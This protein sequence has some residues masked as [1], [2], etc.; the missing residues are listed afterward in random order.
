MNKHKKTSLLPKLFITFILIVAALFLMSG[1]AFSQQA[2]EKIKPETEKE[3]VYL[4]D[5]SASMVMDN[6]I[7][8]YR[9]IFPEVKA[10]ILG[11]IEGM[12]LDVR[13]KVII[14]T[15]DKDV[16][17][18]FEKEIRSDKD[19][20]EI[21]NK[22][23]SLEA[24]GKY[25][26]TTKAVME[27]LKVLGNE[28]GKKDGIERKVVIYLLTDGKLEPPC[29]PYI[30]WNEV[31][32]RYKDLKKVES[33]NFV[34]VLVPLGP[35]VTSPTG[36]EDEIP[37]K[38]TIRVTP[39]FIDFGELTTKG[40]VAKIELEPLSPTMKI[41]NA[42]INVTSQFKIPSGTL[43]INP[44]KFSVPNEK[45]E[46]DL[47][48]TLAG[49]TDISP[50][51]YE[52]KIDLD[53]TEEGLIL[54]PPSIKAKFSIVSFLVNPKTADFGR[55]KKG[56]ARCV[57]FSLKGECLSSPKTINIVAKAE[58][59]QISFDPNP[60]EFTITPTESQNFFTITVKALKKLSWQKKYTTQFILK[61][62]GFPSITVPIIVRGSFPWGILLWMIFSIA[63]ICVGI[64]VYKKI[65]TAIHHIPQHGEVITL[66][67]QGEKPIRIGRR[68]RSSVGENG[69]SLWHDSVSLIHAEI[70]REKNKFIIKRMEGSLYV[71]GD[72]I[73]E[74]EI[75]EKDSIGIGDFE[76]EFILEEDIPS[77]LV[78][79][80]PKRRYK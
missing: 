44:A 33:L 7:K 52:G 74:K 5:T 71:N 62:E 38:I 54:L 37:T 40:T 45:T 68:R 30:T 70:R 75:E 48:L 50:G 47:T 67:L 65:L 17:E 72:R 24:K 49:L 64:I 29:T 31:K 61:S 69:V 43:L 28:A 14:I 35:N 77:L 18:P 56:E 32:A 8:G 78:R 73:E 66:S 11:H 63:L 19:K 23:N 13:E 58:E 46:K 22:I 80:A 26:Y 41:E 10:W 1:I 15:F 4:I 76:F 55:L 51:I 39:A 60:K 21:R 27:T 12:P 59:D 2:N 20:D 25:T 42:Q 16:S 79:N 34:W 3:T 53:S 36:L 6:P 9:N 57:K